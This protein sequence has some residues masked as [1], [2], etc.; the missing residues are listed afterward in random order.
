MRLRGE[1]LL[2]LRE[3]EDMPACETG[4]KFIE[5]FPAKKNEAGLLS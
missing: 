2:S 4:M 5:G 1:Q 3:L